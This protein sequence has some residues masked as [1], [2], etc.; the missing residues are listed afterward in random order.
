MVAS[1]CVYLSMLGMGAIL[2]GYVVPG[3][4]LIVLGGGLYLSSKARAMIAF[5]IYGALHHLR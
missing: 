4:A 1:G 5:L 3:L 2:F